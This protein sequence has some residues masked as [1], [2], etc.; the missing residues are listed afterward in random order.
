M[1]G[2]GCVGTL[3]RAWSLKVSK[4][5]SLGIAGNWVGCRGLLGVLGVRDVR[6]TGSTFALG[7]LFVH[8]LVD[9]GSL[10]L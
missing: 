8:G 3:R 9:V 1:G 4:D 6:V 2:A 7:E 5:G 10:M